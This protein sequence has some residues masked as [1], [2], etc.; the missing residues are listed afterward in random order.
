MSFFPVNVGTHKLQAK[1]LPRVGVHYK[2][3]GCW[4]VGTNKPPTQRCKQQIKE[5]FSRHYL[6]TLGTIYHLPQ[7]SFAYA[8]RSSSKGDPL[9]WPLLAPLAKLSFAFIPIFT[10][11][12]SLN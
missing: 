4:A 5:R 6:P 11:L 2:L 7:L 3:R 8:F 9:L 10:L 1:Q 12:Y